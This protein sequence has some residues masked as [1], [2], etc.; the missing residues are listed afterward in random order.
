MHF[1]I[2][3]F[4]EWGKKHF[5]Q[6]TARV[7]ISFYLFLWFETRLALWEFGKHMQLVEEKIRD[8]LINQFTLTLSLSI[9]RLLRRSSQQSHNKFRLHIDTIHETGRCAVRTT[10][11]KENEV[12][13][14]RVESIEIIH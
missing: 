13:D 14:S 6:S 7:I 3:D 10:K 2:S 1:F 5:P 4:I 9:Y 8:F 11:K 12:M